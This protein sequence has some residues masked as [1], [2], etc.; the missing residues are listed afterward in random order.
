M[1]A[2]I[3]ASVAA[4]GAIGAVGRYAVMSWVGQWLGHG[5]PYGTLA[6][7]ILGSFILAAL[8]ETLAQVWSPSPEIRALLVVGM[9]GA[10][11]TFSTFSLD[12]FTLF[13]RGDMAAAG[14]YVLAS[15]VLSLAGF[16]L[17]L[18]AMRW[19]LV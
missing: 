13:Q 7:N 15:V 2:G 3:L 16:F 8:I 4:G 11:T 14:A 9:L 18:T 5:F 1:N 12:V 6:V 19:V 10:F 17:G